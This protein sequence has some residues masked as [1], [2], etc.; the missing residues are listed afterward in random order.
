MKKT[1]YLL[2]L[3][4]ALLLAGAGL[5]DPPAGEPPLATVNEEPILPGD[6][7]RQLARI[8]ESTDAIDRSAFDTDR[9]MFKLV[10]DVLIGQEARS[11]G[12]AEEPEILEQMAEYRDDLVYKY[13]EKVE[14]A[15]RVQPEPEAV[16][17]LFHKQYNEMQLRVITS[18]DEAVADEILAELRQGADMETLARERSVDHIAARGGLMKSAPRI[19]LHRGMAQVA[20]QLDVGEIGGPVRTDLGWTVF[21]VE[22]KTDVDP[23]R[24][25]ELE[26]QLRAILRQEKARVLREALARTS[27][28][29]HLVVLDQELVKQLKP[30]RQ[31]DARLVAEAPEP[32]RVV[33]QVGE[34]R[35]VRAGDYAHALDKRWKG[36]RNEEAAVAA[37]PIILNNLIERE[38][39]IAEGDRRGYGDLPVVQALLHSRETQLLVPRYLE[40]IVA[41]NVEITAEEMQEYYDEHKSQFLRPPRVRL[42]QVT[43]ATMEEAEKVAGLLRGGADIAW[44][45]QQH[46]TDGFKDK[47]G[48]RGWMVPTPGLD[49]LQDRLLEVQ[50]GDVLD[51][52]GVEGNYIVLKM[53]AREE[54]GP[55]EFD[56]ISGNVRQTLFTDR[57]RM[58]LDR[59]ITTLRER[60]EIVLYDDR[61]QALDISGSFVEQAEEEGSPGGHGH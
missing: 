30:V 4:V 39:L 52:F 2:L 45:A 26:G 1:F 60:S 54:Q 7:E 3:P 23:A 21:R 61:I 34:H 38:L 42:G 44:V 29:H 6:L 22:A 40:E 57:F 36:V 59:F 48:M 49:A 58:V 56:Q 11:A 46:S 18:Y 50:A 12:M 5:P 8:H 20:F 55:F 24:F 51:P 31:P 41:A 47:G 53:M 35:T 13:L 37:A 32:D 14:I 43:V 28:E 9:L 16:Q 10:N 33:A 25:E 15:D 27:G 17:R 19:D